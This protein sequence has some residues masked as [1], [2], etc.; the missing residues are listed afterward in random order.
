[1]KISFA[2][3]AALKGH[4]A[5]VFAGPGGKLFSHGVK[6][7]ADSGGAITRAIKAASFEGKK[8]QLLELL[9]LP[10]IG[11]TR[12]IVAGVGKAGDIDAKAAEEVGGAL[13]AKLQTSGETAV[14]IV[15][16]D[17]AGLKLTGGDFA[18]R[19]AYGLKLRSYRFDR[20]RTKEEEGKKPTLTKVVVMVDEAKKAEAAFARLEAVANGVFFARD[21]VSEPGNVIYPE[22]YAKEIKK[23]E[24]QGLKIQVL[25][26]KAMKK[27]G[28]G[29]LLGV[30]QGSAHEAKLAILEWR[31]AKNAKAK[32]IA[33]VGKGLTFDSGG[34]SLKPGEGMQ[35]M[36]FDMAGSAAVVGVMQALAARQ[37]RVNAVGV[38]ALVENMP[39]DKAQRPGDVVK[40]M[41][42][43]TIEVI[44]TD[45]EGR[46][47]LADAL[48]YTQ[49]RFKPQCVI[50]LATLTGAMIIA[51]GHEY[52]GVFSNNDTLAK[53]LI[54]AGEA[55][56]DLV[57]R[58]PIGK[59]YEKDI[60]SDIA[61][62]KNVGAGRTAG[63][64]AGAV[65]LQRF[66]NDLPWA[67]IDIAGTAWIK[68]DKPTTPKGATGYGVRLLD[69]LVADYYEEK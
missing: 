3:P 6:L 56:G 21:L 10:H 30:S 34:I 48:W 40:S 11:A 26:E 23:L 46:L 67:H 38:V 69:R 18:A 29:A 42:G 54:A 13:I 44:N 39:S 65:F 22:S 31:G 47:V 17:I 51:L 68:K 50:D 52:A 8:N 63:S 19:V 62:M 15:I 7:D 5:V 25:D 9:G 4:A 49:D 64:I 45:A 61:D 60:E 14:H 33:F 2:K 35:D 24:K 43:Q 12:L 37:A 1:M 53:Q 59:M 27:L 58:M 55:E 36:K 57:W 20:Y 32:P 16:D 41:S 66:V 28:M